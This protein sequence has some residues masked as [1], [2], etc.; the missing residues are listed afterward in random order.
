MTFR[1]GRRK[2][3]PDVCNHRM[4]AEKTDRNDPKGVLTNEALNDEEFKV[5]RTDIE[6]Q[7][8]KT[9]TYT[10][11]VYMQGKL[12][13]TDYANVGGF[14]SL[15]RYTA[16]TT[17]DKPYYLCMHVKADPISP[18]LVKFNFV[19]MNG[20]DSTIKAIFG[21]SASTSGYTVKPPSYVQLWCDDDDL[22]VY[23]TT[24]TKYGCNLSVAE[25]NP[26]EGAVVQVMYAI[27]N[28]GLYNRARTGNLSPS[29]DSSYS[30]SDLG[31]TVLAR[32]NP[33]D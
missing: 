30:K 8:E 33:I 21:P 3:Q 10:K 4:Q 31:G 18:L 20:K 27:L 1:F 23:A 2:G 19:R 16:S 25:K 11:D 14:L 5:P 15:M 12:A 28:A 22:E 6:N 7:W 32:I 13:T 17:S 29:A 9:Q 26:I 24:S